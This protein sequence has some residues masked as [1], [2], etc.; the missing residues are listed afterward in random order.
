M[1]VSSRTDLVTLKYVRRMCTLVCTHL[2]YKFTQN[3]GLHRAFRN[4]VQGYDLQPDFL[5]C[6]S[7]HCHQP[8]IYTAINRTDCANTTKKVMSLL[9]S[10]IGR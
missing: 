3:K 2:S 5:P 1:S 9:L 10:I 7:L 6:E 4:G 8:D